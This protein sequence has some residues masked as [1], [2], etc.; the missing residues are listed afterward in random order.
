MAAQDENVTP[1][2]PFPVESAPGWLKAL[3]VGL[4]IAIIG[5]LA[6]ILFKIV[7]GD[8]TE[9]A[10]PLSPAAAAPGQHV[11][12]LEAGDYEIERPI[13]ATLVSVRPSGEEVYLRF[14][15]VSGGDEIV[16]LNRR[17]GDISRI[18]V[19]ISGN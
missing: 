19:P 12:P 2:T 5:M 9:E 3:V 10:E 8:A 4:G 7:A 17:T 14:R 18:A 13:G 6:L 16:I 15:L 11:A 1:E